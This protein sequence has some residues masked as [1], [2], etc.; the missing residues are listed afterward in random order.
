[1]LVPVGVAVAARDSL[2]DVARGLQARYGSR[3]AVRE[4]LH[5]FESRG[6]DVRGRAGD[7]ARRARTDVEGRLR[8]VRSD[9]EGR[10]RA[11]RADVTTHA[12]RA[13]AR[14]RDVAKPVTDRFAA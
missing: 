8:A 9:V 2:T 4:Q 3:D 13:V 10:T 14:V 7:E 11:V 5:R 12:D 1:M 6:A